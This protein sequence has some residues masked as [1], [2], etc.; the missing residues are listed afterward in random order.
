[1]IQRSSSPV[2]VLTALLAAVA[3]VVACDDAPTVPSAAELSGI[4]FAKADCNADPSHPSCKNDGGKDD[5]GS[6]DGGSDDVLFDFSDDAV[7]NGLKIADPDGGDL[8]ND[9]GRWLDIG[10][11]GSDGVPAVELNYNDTQ[12]GEC[13]AR[14]TTDDITAEDLGG[15][16]T[17]TPSGGDMFSGRLTVDK[18]NATSTEH[19]VGVQFTDGSLTILVALKG[20]LGSPITVTG[21]GSTNPADLRFDGGT[22]R[23]RAKLGGSSGTDPV[24]DCPHADFV[25]AHVERQ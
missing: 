21:D 22:V 11:A 5:G 18:K 9:G 17:A 20:N 2:T 12:N 3:L 15:Y 4:A 24:L 25:Q 8:F 16:L 19:R 13:V 23:V 10:F 1:M 6:D 14:N 7:D